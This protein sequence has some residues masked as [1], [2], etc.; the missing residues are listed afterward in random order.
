MYLKI[1]SMLTVIFANASLYAVA[2]ING[3][4][5]LET[6]TYFPIETARNDK[7][8]EFY[9]SNSDSGTRYAGMSGESL[10]YTFT[11]NSTYEK[12]SA[13]HADADFRIKNTVN[14]SFGNPTNWN[15]RDEIYFNVVSGKTL[16]IDNL[17]VTCSNPYNSSNYIV[18]GSGGTKVLGNVTGNYIR[19]LVHLTSG[20][21]KTNSDLRM[22]SYKTSNGATLNLGG[23]LKVEGSWYLNWSD[24]N[25][26]ANKT[27]INLNGYDFVLAGTLQVEANAAAKADVII[28]FG[29]EDDVSIFALNETANSSN[30]N[31]I[32]ITDFEYGKNLFLL[33]TPF[34][35]I[36]SML[37]FEGYEGKEIQSKVLTE[38]DIVNIGNGID[39]S[40]LGY[41][42]YYVIP[43]PSTYALF[44]GILALGFV[45]YKRRR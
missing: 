26:S 44:F 41:T 42:S 33:K 31:S 17:N 28:S 38:L 23:D 30:I 29:D 6:G 1:F 45:A 7:D 12:F 34:D 27:T 24:A 22:G 25:Y 18:F 43:E 8:A 39:D 5:N 13:F 40:Y 19:S 4:G 36:E 37:S 2:T 11:D 35:N 21:L 15:V 9:I 10:N 14:I 3:G 32:V 20:V 16:Y